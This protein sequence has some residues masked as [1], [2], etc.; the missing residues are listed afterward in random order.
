MKI[1]IKHWWTGSILFEGDF[2]SVAEAVVA[3]VKKG[4]DLGGADLRGADLRSANLRSANLRSAN[5]GGADLRSANL[6]GADLRSANLGGADLGGADLRSANLGGAKNAGLAIASTRIL[7]EGSIIGWKKI[8]KEIIVK[9]S[10]PET[11]RRSHAFGR[12]CRTESAIVLAMFEADGNAFDGVGVSSYD[13]TFEYRVGATVKPKEP[14][15]EDYTNECASGIHFF[16]TR[17]EAAA[18]SL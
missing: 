9:L 13:S 10:I 7:P 2:S 14:F 8:S 5:L 18:Y 4:A 15:A 3:A 1:E 11:S 17:E 12:K 6:G 16:I